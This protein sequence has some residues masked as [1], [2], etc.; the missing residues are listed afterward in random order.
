MIVILDD[1]SSIHYLWDKKFAGLKLTNSI[2]HFHFDHEF[3]SWITANTNSLEQIIFLCD[4]ELIG[5][6]LQGLQLI[7]KY[8]TKV[9]TSLL[10]T[11]YYAFHELAPELLRIQTQLL[12]KEL[13]M[14][15]AIDCS[16]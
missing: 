8:Q 16:R 2:H 1:D 9:K 4:N 3:E 11:S 5:S 7:E 13:V 6:K 10:V 12:P 15:L 14:Q